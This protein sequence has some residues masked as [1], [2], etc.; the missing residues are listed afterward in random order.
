MWKFWNF[1]LEKVENVEKK[2]SRRYASG[3]MTNES[4]TQ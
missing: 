4:I 3:E 1:K 2:I